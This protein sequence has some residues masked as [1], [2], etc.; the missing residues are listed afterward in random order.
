MLTSNPHPAEFAAVV[1]NLDDG[2]THSELSENLRDLVARVRDTGKAGSLTLTLVV[3]P[4]PGTRNQVEIKDEIKLRVPQFARATSIF[5]AAEDNSL[6]R[7]DPNQ[8]ALDG[9]RFPGRIDVTT[10]EIKE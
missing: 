5:F 4:R 7:N 1:L 9:L 3:A 2:A 8:P 10:G 6:T